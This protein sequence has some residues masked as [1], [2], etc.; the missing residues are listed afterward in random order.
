MDKLILDDGRVALIS[1][2]KKDDSTA[3][4]LRFIN[5]LIDEKTNI[6]ADKKFNLKQEE[7]WKKMQIE[8]QKKRIGYTLVARIS[9]KIAGTSGANLG[10][11]KE[12]GNASLGIAIAKE[13][14]GIGL[15][16]AL[17]RLNIRKARKIYNPKNIVLTVFSTN[18]IAHNLYS[19]VGFREFARFPK[20]I[21]H[22]GKYCDMIYMKL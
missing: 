3:E 14:R 5:R 17:L 6:L 10:K 15:G 22:R 2:V 16:E 19:K 9:G 7:E 20:W 8:N 13:F 18:K 11:F 12:K 1:F 4:Y 21:K